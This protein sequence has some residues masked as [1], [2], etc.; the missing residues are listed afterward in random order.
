MRVFNILTLGVAVVSAAPYGSTTTS[1]GQTVRSTTTT[2]SPEACNQASITTCM[3]TTGL[4]GPSC[5]V[6]ICTSTSDAELRRR[7]DF[8][9]AQDNDDT[10][11][12][13]NEDSLLDCAV[14]Q[15]RNPDICFQ[16]LCL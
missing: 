13:C 6:Q 11:A 14:S 9:I 16:Q 3:A 15:W 7:Q 12:S 8:K 1:V 4:D 2:L 10:P 5:F